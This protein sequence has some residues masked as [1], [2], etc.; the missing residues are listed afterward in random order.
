MVIIG[1]GPAGLGAAYELAK[2]GFKVVVLERGKRPGSK[3]LYGGRIYLTAISKVSPDLCK[4]MSNLGRRVVRERIMLT[5]SKTCMSI[6]IETDEWS[7]GIVTSLTRFVE[8]LS[9]KVEEAGA[10]IVTS[11]KVDALH[12]HGNKTSGVRCG[13]DNIL[14]E[15][16]IDAEGV[17]RILLEKSGLVPKLSPGDVA[18][19]VKE[20]Y[21]VDPKDIEKMF[22]LE[23]NRGMVLLALGEV[24]D[25]FPGGCFMY[26]D[27]SHI[28][29]GAVLYLSNYTKFRRTFPEV[30]DSLYKLP[31]FRRVVKIG[32]RVEYGARLLPVRP[33]QRA[34]MDGLVTV[35]DAG[36]FL[37]HV[38]PIIRGVD[39][40]FVSGV[41]A[42][43]AVAE[44]LEKEKR[45]SV[46]TYRSLFSKYV[47]D[48]PL[49]RDIELFRRVYTYYEAHDIY[50]RYVGFI[51]DLLREYLEVKNGVKSLNEA[52]YL[53][54]RKHG[55][56][57]W[58]LAMDYLRR[59]RKM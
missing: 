7:G 31:L 29:V 40:A 9:Q 15:V 1:A 10:Y 56:S 22:D 26:V 23:E 53:S 28:H 3:N 17:N 5:H 19:G 8:W 14:A 39:Y 2:R 36:G 34:E 27:K 4:E 33:L 54:M 42:G 50:S 25:Y 59:F 58:G 52:M 57:I 11:A 13:S 49:M 44:M 24:L 32:E 12:V 41:C 51:V 48:T 35:G 20:V 46:M 45:P 38:G 43:R 18:I 21:R 16:V 47:R 37:I 55:L 6:E 30:L